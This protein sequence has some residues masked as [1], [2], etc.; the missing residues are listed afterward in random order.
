MKVEVN[1]STSTVS[2]DW[3]ISDRLPE[4]VI[5]S[6]YPIRCQWSFPLLNRSLFPPLSLLYNWLVHKDIS[7]FFRRQNQSQWK[8]QF[9]N[10]V[11]LM[12]ASVSSMRRINNDICPSSS[13]GHRRRIWRPSLPLIT[14]RVE[15]W[16]SR[17]S[18]SGQREQL[19]WIPASVVATV[20]RIL[21]VK[22]STGKCFGAWL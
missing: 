13:C 2:I 22:R 19:K 1:Q 6:L 18:L 12:S 11:T 15:F 14:R 9:E 4:C 17:I 3:A 16:I 8:I 21:I 10:G 20:E 5:S 7:S